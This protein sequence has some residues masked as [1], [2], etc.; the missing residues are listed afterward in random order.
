MLI[1][2]NYLLQN[3]FLQFPQLSGFFRQSVPIHRAYLTD[4][5]L[6]E[7]LNF[8]NE[9]AY[10]VQDASHIRPARLIARDIVRDAA[11]FIETIEQDKLF[12]HVDSN[13]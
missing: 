8:A 6:C 1:T 11:V 12:M 13:I 4:I 3:Q 10:R 9:E 7:S 2:S 5:M